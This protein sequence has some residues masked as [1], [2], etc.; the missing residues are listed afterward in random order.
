[1]DLPQFTHGPADGRR[2]LLVHGLNSSAA[3]WGRVGDALVDAGWNVTTVD[4]RGHGDSAGPADPAEAHD[5][6][7]DA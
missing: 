6:R 7:D 1:M 4:L 2:A 3:S 5:S